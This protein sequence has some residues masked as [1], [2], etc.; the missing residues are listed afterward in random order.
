MVEAAIQYKAHGAEAF[1]GVIDPA[2]VG[3][4][5]MLRFTFNGVDRGFELKSVYEGR[6]FPEVMIF[7]ESD[8]P[9][10]NVHGKNAGKAV[11]P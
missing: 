8:G 10:F 11:Q 9:P 1:R 3:P 4:F 5:E 7:V 6:G 2:G